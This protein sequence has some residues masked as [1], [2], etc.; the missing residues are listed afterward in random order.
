MNFSASPTVAVPPEEE[1]GTLVHEDIIN[2]PT[3]RERIPPS[4]SW[5]DLLVKFTRNLLGKM[6]GWG[7]QL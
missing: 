6:W 3:L 4:H 1:V 5:R 2:S 7:K